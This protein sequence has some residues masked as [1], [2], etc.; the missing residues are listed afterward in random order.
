MG[1][2]LVRRGGTG[3]ISHSFPNPTY[4]LK[5]TLGATYSS[6]SDGYASLIVSSTNP[7][8][9]PSGEL[10]FFSKIRAN[11]VIPSVIGPSGVDFNIQGSLY[12]NTIIRWV[13][14]VTTT[15][16]IAWGTTWTARNSSGAQ[17]HPAKSSANALSSLNRALFA[18]TATANTSAGIQ[19]T[20]V[21]AWRGNAVGL[22]GFFFFARFGMSVIGSLTG[23]R[24]LIGL[25]VLNG[26]LTVDPSTI[27]NTVAIIKDA[28]DTTW[29]FLTRNTSTLTK[30]DT[31][32]TVTVNQV[33][34]IYIHVKPNDGS[35]TFHLKDA[36][37]GIDIYQQTLTTGMIDGT[38]FMYIHCQ[39]QTTTTA[40]S[41]LSLGQMYLESD[42]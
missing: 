17:S 27:N 16:S 1:Q 21:V 5:D 34:D 36:V 6:I 25:S 8:T 2:G 42:V 18:T 37:T 26:T 13:P 33:L 19:S 9:P 14:G 20:Q 11:K 29:Q 4:I 32:S 40:V 35:A 23:V 30:I 10:T 39:V 38:T 7:D 24:V 3:S 22:G 15:V 28:A 31:A 41:S 12:G